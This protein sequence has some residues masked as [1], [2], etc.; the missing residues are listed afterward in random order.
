M[1]TIFILLVGCSI[2]TLANYTPYH[3][4]SLLKY[5]ILYI[6]GAKELKKDIPSTTHYKLMRGKPDDKE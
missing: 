5:S 3:N 2:L 6:L 1:F 4:T